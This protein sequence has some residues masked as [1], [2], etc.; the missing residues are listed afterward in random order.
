VTTAAPPPPPAAPDPGADLLGAL[1]GGR[2]APPAPTGTVPPAPHA[3][4]G[5][6]AFVRAIVAPHVVPSPDPQLAQ[7]VAAVDLATASQMRAVLHDPGFQALEAAW[8]GVAWL[9]SA[10]ELDEP[11][12]LHLFDVSRDEVLAD[13]IGAGGQVERSGLHTALVD[14]WRNQP[15]GEPWSVLAGLWRF[16]PSDADIGLLAALGIVASQAGGPFLGDA[17]R[18]LAG[19]ADDPALAGWRTLRGSEV[20]PWIGLAAPRVLLRLPYG[21][22]TDPIER[23]AFEEL[24]GGPGHDR[25]LWGS[26][27]LACML[28]IGRAFGERGWAFEPG[29]VREIG[30]LP[31]FVYTTGDGSRE[32]QACAEHYLGEQ[33][34]QALL[35]A[36]IMALASHRHRNAVTIPR[37]QSIASPAQGLAGLG[38]SAAAGAR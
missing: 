32:M 20:A 24:P 5:I 38:A 17:E 18:S 9:V 13:I 21:R 14:R 23:F 6:E 11:L 15:G 3:A 2:P 16:G 36:G 34:L 30:D 7:L 19:P 27:A 28:A 29:D 37:F 22:S 4:P 25:L 26:A 33:A 35:D 31:A 8:R 10:L 1:L 12:Q